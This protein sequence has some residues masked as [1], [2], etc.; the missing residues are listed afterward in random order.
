MS[1]A[2]LGPEDPLA[3]A[4]STEIIGKCHHAQEIAVIHI[5]VITYW[6]EHAGSIAYDVPIMSDLTKKV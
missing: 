5:L 6:R 1:K 3:S 4:S 2:S